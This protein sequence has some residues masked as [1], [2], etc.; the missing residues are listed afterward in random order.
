V[1]DD[2]EDGASETWLMPG[3]I[4]GKITATAPDTALPQNAIRSQKKYGKK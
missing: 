1:L 2:I 3:K 4:S